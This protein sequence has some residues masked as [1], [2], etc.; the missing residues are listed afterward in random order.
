MQTPLRPLQIEMEQTFI[1]GGS[2]RFFCDPDRADLGESVP[3]VSRAAP[4]GWKTDATDARKWP[5]ILQMSHEKLHNV[6]FINPIGKC[7]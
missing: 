4:L 5:R 6:W 7:D 1:S 3:G 2:A